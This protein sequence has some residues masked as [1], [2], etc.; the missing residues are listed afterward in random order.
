[1]H[2]DVVTIFPEMF[3][4]VVGS[5]ILKRAQEARRVQ[6]GV[7]DLR[8]YTSDTHRTV[9][10]RP[11]GGGAGMVMKP[12]PLFKAIEAVEAA[13][14]DPKGKRPASCRVV[15]MTP[16]GECFSQS[17]AQ[18]LSGLK[19]LVL[20]CGHY[21]GVDER[22]RQ[23]LVDQEISIG[24]YVLTGGEL[25]AMAVIDA[26]VRLI[27]GV[28]GHEDATEEESFVNGLLEYPQY[29]RPPV[30]RGMAVPQALQSGHHAQVAK[31]RKLHAV[32]RTWSRRPD[33]MASSKQQED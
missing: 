3:G 22:V 10:D 1:M 16:Q 14:H 27:P 31:W 15:L 23:A 32:A 21:E 7:H 26:V 5:S 2:I 29:T 11:Y 9:D 20:I 25:P 28:L 33:L 12:E 24:D 19:H 13:R 18:E 17:M 8:D 4:P 6:I 30:F